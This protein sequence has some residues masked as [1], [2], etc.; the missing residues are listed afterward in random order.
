[1]TAPFPPLPPVAGLPVLDTPVRPDWLDHNGHMNVAAYLI[2]FDQGCCALCSLAGIGPD[3]IAETGHTVFVGQAN[4]VYRREVHAGDRL[5]ITARLRD[6]AA[7]R[8]Q[9]Y[10][11]MWRAGAKGAELAAAC[12]ELAVGV[13]LETRRPAPFPADVAAW[14][15]A[16]RAADDSP[17]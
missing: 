10:L 1:M 3:R 13:R 6:L 12:E 7:D 11:T 2:A 4:V 5:C 9:L 8:M 17:I 16:L 15:A 14:L